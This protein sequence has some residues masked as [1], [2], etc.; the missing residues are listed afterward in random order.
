[1]FKG[2]KNTLQLSL[3]YNI[4]KLYQKCQNGIQHD[5]YF[6]KIMTME[7]LLFS[8]HT[9][10]SSPIV[11]VLCLIAI[12]SCLIV[13]IRTF[14]TQQ[15]VFSI[16]VIGITDQL[17]S[18]SIPVGFLELLALVPVVPVLC[19]RRRRLSVELSQDHLVMRNLCT[20]SA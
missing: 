5:Q 7:I 20:I 8:C 17:I 13:H 4:A 12:I 1:M 10:S 19:R 6:S 11:S 2:T 18:Q 14:F 9:F 16:G 15:V 3:N